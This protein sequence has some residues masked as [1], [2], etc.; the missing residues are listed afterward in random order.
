MTPRVTRRP[1]RV[2]WLVTIG[3]TC[4]LTVSFVDEA[5]TPLDLSG[6]TF[7]ASIDGFAGGAT[8]AA[9]PVDDTG[10]AGG[11][12]VLTIDDTTTAALARDVVWWLAEQVGGEPRTLLDGPL[13]VARRGGAGVGHAANALTVQI[14]TSSVVVITTAVTGPAGSGGGGGDIDG[15]TAAGTGTGLID[16][17]GA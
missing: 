15:G 13:R 6:R 10:A 2:E 5:G 12:L 7:T 9:I 14:T 8:V 3:D 1:A 16:G 17:G 4:E 11:V